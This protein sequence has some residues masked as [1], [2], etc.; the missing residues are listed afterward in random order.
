MKISQLLIPKYLQIVFILLL[1]FPFKKV[2]AQFAYGADIGWLSQFENEGKVFKDSSGTKKNCMEILKEKGFNA[3]RFRVWVNPVNGYCNKRDVAY[4]AHRADSMGFKVMLDFHYSDY[5]AD[6]A[7]QNKPA[8]WAN[9]SFTQL[10][11]DVYMHTYEVID[12]LKSIGVTPKWV[13]IGNETDDGML[14]EDGRASVH[15]NNFAELIKS[16]YNAVKAVDCTIQV[17]VHISNGHDNKMFRW[18]FDSL[19]SNG[20]KWDIIGMSVYPYWAKLPWAADDSLAVINMKDMINRYQSKVMVCET[21]Y[22]FDQ[23]IEAYKFLRDLI[24]KTKSLGGLGVFYW[25]PESYGNGYQLG[26][27]DPVTKQPTS[28]L[29]AF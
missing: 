14:W 21:G 17:I 29:D 25:E 27:W 7:K 5:W 23:P 11:K 28:A 26:A 1:I 3:L 2:N 10:L 24:E 4:M 12:T 22:Q 15:M 6:P 9:H 16:G 18:M 8:A 20:A 13:Q 19:K